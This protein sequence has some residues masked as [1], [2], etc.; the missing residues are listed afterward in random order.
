MYMVRLCE[1]V[2]SSSSCPA[3]QCTDLNYKLYQPIQMDWDT[4]DEVHTLRVQTVWDGKVLVYMWTVWSGHALRLKWLKVYT[5]AHTYQ[6]QPECTHHAHSCPISPCQALY[7]YHYTC[8]P[9]ALR[10]LHHPEVLSI[11]Y[12]QW[13]QLQILVILYVF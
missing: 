11:L 7:Y 12:E 5:H 3:L 1:K 10:P 4:A 2:A 13:F 6:M 8:Y 9:P